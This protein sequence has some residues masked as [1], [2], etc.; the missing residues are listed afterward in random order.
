VA[1]RAPAARAGVGASLGPG[2]V[3]GTYVGAY[4]RSGV[5]WRVLGV[6]D[7]FGVCVGRCVLC[8]AGEGAG[9]GWRVLCGAGVGA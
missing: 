4:V 9:V 2:G 8:G 6:G 3:V 7:G 1:R 5:D